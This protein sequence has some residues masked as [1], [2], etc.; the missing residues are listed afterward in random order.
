MVKLQPAMDTLDDDVAMRLA[1]S[2]A[3]MKIF[4]SR[5]TAYKIRRDQ[6]C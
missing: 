3:L 2:I 6:H 5:Y 1:A 4:L